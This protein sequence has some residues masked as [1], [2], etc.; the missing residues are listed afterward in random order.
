MRESKLKEKADLPCGPVIKN[1]SAN[2]AGDMGSS[3]GGT[4]DP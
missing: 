3:L 1:L 2:N 4:K